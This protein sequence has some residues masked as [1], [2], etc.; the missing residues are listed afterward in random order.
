MQMKRLYLIIACMCAG[1]CTFASDG[2]VVADK[3]NRN[4]IELASIA[5]L[6]SDSTYVDGAITDER[7]IFRL[8]DAKTKQVKFIKVSAVGYENIFQTISQ[9][10][11]DTIFMT[12]DESK[13]L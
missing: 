11:G 12:V 7:G 13:L 1:L 3:E 2:L 4:P 8:L 6:S 5:F 9:L 10:K